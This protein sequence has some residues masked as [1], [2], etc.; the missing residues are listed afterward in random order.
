[1]AIRHVVKNGECMTGIALAYGFP[2]HTKIYD[3]P[4]NAELKRRRPNPNVLAPGD[5]VYVP[6][7]EARWVSVAVNGAH[8]FE[9]A[10]PQ[11]ELRL[12]LRDHAGDA[13]VNEPYT[14]ELEGQAAREGQT[15][16]NG[17]VREPVPAEAKLATLVVRERVLRLRLGTLLPVREAPGHDVRGLQARLRNLGYDLG[18]EDGELGPRTRAAI[19]VFQH[20]QGLAIDGQPSDAVLDALLDE[21]GS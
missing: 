7:R 1:M 14:L 12:V 5:V 15:D 18:A 20:E 19:A 21:H 10:R 9:L 4:D 2:D 8:R 16:G 6:N 11:K 17:V 13:L 3:H